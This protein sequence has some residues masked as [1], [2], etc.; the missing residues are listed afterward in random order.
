MKSNPEE[1]LPVAGILVLF[2]EPLSAEFIRRLGSLSY[3]SDLSVATRATQCPF[4][5]AFDFVRGTPTTEI[6]FYERLQMVNLQFLHA[7]VLG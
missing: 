5:N 2:D 7:D 4:D 3:L 6:D 1:N